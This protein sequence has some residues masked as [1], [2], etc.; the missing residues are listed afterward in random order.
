MAEHCLL[1]PPAPVAAPIVQHAAVEPPPVVEEPPAVDPVLTLPPAPVPVA[2]AALAVETV[3]EV[4]FLT[5]LLVLSPVYILLS[6]FYP[7]SVA[8]VP[9]VVSGSFILGLY[10]N[11]L[12]MTLQR[13]LF[14]PS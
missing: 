11:I 6:C 13:S 8:L 3:E 14:M 7:L 2:D 5:I 12:L 4:I 1:P 10:A 9:T